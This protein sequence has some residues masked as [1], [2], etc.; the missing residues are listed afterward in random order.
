M[1]ETVVRTG[2]HAGLSPQSA[3]A[4]KCRSS[5]EPKNLVAFG[6]QY[7][8]IIFMYILSFMLMFIFTFV[9]YLYHIENI[10]YMYLHISLCFLCFHYVHIHTH[11]YMYIYTYICIH[12]YIM[13]LSALIITLIFK[14]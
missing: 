7:T 6:L 2:A 12:I 10:I 14:F 11:I 5:K 1:S 9:Q 13:F 8:Q 4:I 3:E